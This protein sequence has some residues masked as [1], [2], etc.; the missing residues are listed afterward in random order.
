MRTVLAILQKGQNKYIRH[1][2][3]S[4]PFNKQANISD[5]LTNAPQVKFQWTVFLRTHIWYIV[6][7]YTVYSDL[8]IGAFY[9]PDQLMSFIWLMI[10][11]GA[12]AGWHPPKIPEHKIVWW[13]YRVNFG[14]LLEI[15]S[16]LC[17]C[18]DAIWTPIW[19]CHNQPSPYWHFMLQ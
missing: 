19:F 16:W 7:D 8:V 17:Y 13:F 14:I 12:T 6:P 11:C 9:V 10:N 2:L 1:H 5:H 18:Y 15:N 3:P 4:N